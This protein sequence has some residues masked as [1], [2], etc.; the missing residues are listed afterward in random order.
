MKKKIYYLWLVTFIIS[1]AMIVLV[2]FGPES[3]ST[4]ATT[5]GVFSCVV[6]IVAA[7]T[8]EVT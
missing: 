5:A 3:I 7:K 1:I 8:Y 4:K 6:G 2:V